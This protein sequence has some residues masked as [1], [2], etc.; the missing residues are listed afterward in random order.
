MKLVWLAVLVLAFAAIGVGPL[1]DRR[2]DLKE[3]AAERR[4]P[5][6]G[7]IVEVDGRAVHAVV[8]GSGPDLILIHGASGN[9]RDWTFDFVDRVSGRYRVIAIDR[10]GLGW[11]EQVDPAHDR[12][13]TSRADTPA[14][15]ARQMARAAAALGVRDPVVVGQSYGGAVALAWALD[16]DAAVR[17]AAVVSVAGATMPWPG[18]VSGLYRLTGSAAGGALV[19]PLI[20]AFPPRQRVAEALRSIF[21]P[22][23]AP[24]GY[25]EQVG[26]AL[27]LRRTAFR[28]N[29]RQVKG[30]LAEVERMAPLYPTL[31]LPVEIVHGTADEVVGHDVH[32]PPTAAAIPGAHLTTL[33]GIGHMPHHV[34]PDAVIAAVDRA[35][36]RAGLR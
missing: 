35:A 20:A 2:A 27:V 32:A 11:S 16:A 4:Y 8:T 12:A 33:P 26:A 36:A 1:I 6:L 31:D 23:A 28:A 9:V 25:A 5:P 13:W 24:E 7:R 3:A 17:P 30:L 10:P 22:Q 14:A 15:Q 34:A 19:V 29:A 21:A 18:G